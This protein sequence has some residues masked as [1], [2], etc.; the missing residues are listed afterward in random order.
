MLECVPPSLQREPT[1]EVDTFGDQEKAIIVELFAQCDA[2]GSGVLEMSEI[3]QLLTKITGADREQ[4]AAMKQSILAKYDKN[5]DSALSLDEF[6]AM[7]AH[8]KALSRKHASLDAAESAL[9]GMD[10]R[11]LVAR[12][13]ELEARERDLEARVRAWQEEQDERLALREAE[14]AKGIPCRQQCQ[15]CWDQFGCS[16]FI[17]CYIRYVCSGLRCCRHYCP[18]R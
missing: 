6:I 10:A 2:D 4:V 3:D 12:E 1:W 18:L 5:H 11:A 13:R 16:C 7:I 17:C 15:M 14:R 9:G 8:I